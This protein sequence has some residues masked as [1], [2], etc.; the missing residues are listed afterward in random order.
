MPLSGFVELKTMLKWILKGFGTTG[1]ML[2]LLKAVCKLAE[3]INM[4]IYVK[5]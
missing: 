1:E 3:P 4:T 2:Q 5:F